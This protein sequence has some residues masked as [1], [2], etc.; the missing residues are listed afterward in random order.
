MT[1]PANRVVAA[2]AL[3]RAVLLGRAALTLTAAGVGLR[4]LPDPRSALAVLVVVVVATATA[5][6]VLARHPS[7]VRHPVPVVAVDSIVV[8]GVLIV[9]G[10][11]VPFFCFAAGACALG[12]VV[13]GLRGLGLWALHA[14]LGYAVAGHLLRSSASSPHI[15]VFTLAFPPIEILA[16][17]AAAVATGALVRYVDLS[18]DV[19]ASAQRSAAASERA[20][21][22]RELHDSVGKTL[23][24]VSFA[25]LALPSSLRRQPEL[26]EQLASTVS[27]GAMAAAREARELL[28]GLRLDAPDQDFATTLSRICAHCGTLSGIPVS[29]TAVPV[30]PPAG[31]RYELSRILHEALRNAVEH[32]Q[33]GQVTVTLTLTDHLRLRVHDNGSGFR[34]PGDLSVLTTANHYGLVGMAERARNAGGVL[35]VTSKPGHGTTIEVS[36]PVAFPARLAS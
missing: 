1:L 23:R 9:C 30:D 35:A 22:A 11:G 18:V 10:G 13:L 2:A 20:R 17:I 8:L 12:G 25:A 27:R 33:P 19:V 14:A 21:L 3:G 16:G 15:T 26:A 24:G 5:L 4:V 29:L 6:V 34:V 32:G 31:V 36:V 28:T 7:V